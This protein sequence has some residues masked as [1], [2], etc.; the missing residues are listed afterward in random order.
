MKGPLLAWAVVAGISF[1]VVLWKR[2]NTEADE[3][4]L[5]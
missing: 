2:S 3:V 1:A 4:P 5:T